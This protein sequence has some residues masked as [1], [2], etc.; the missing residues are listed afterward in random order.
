MAEVQPARLA[1][2]FG[3]NEIERSLTQMRARAWGRKQ[4]VAVWQLLRALGAQEIDL[5]ILLREAAQKLNLDPV[6]TAQIIAAFVQTE[7]LREAGSGLLAVGQANGM[8]LEDTEPFKLQPVALEDFLEV[9][10]FFSGPNLGERLAQQWPCLVSR[11]SV[12]V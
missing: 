5:K 12:A 10:A 2:I 8:K 6:A 9:R 7:A 4:A 1:V 3:M 11:E